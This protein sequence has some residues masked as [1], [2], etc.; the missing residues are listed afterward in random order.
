[1][2][3]IKRFILLIKEPGETGYTIEDIATGVTT[4]GETLE[5]AKDMLK[6][7]LELHFEDDGAEVDIEDCF[8][9]TLEVR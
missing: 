9:D 7:A 3:V 1:M 6:E 5:E 8:V 2:I 4:Q